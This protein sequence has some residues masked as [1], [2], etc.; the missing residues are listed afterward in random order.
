MISSIA[1]IRNLSRPKITRHTSV[2][3]SPVNAGKWSLVVSHCSVKAAMNSAVM[4]NS[5]PAV[6]KGITAPS[7]LP[8][9]LP[10]TQ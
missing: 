7:R 5:I 2:L 9:T 10:V 1:G 3:R 4:E 8:S 6:E